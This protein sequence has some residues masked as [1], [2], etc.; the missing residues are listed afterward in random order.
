[1]IERDRDRDRQIERKSERRERKG[2]RERK[3]QRGRNEIETSPDKL[4]SYPAV[5]KGLY[6]NH[7][8]FSVLDSPDTQIQ[9][10][11]T[12]YTLDKEEDSTR[13]VLLVREIVTFPLSVVLH[14]ILSPSIYTIAYQL[15][16]AIQGN[17][18]E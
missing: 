7:N 4:H 9:S 14:S 11:P 5:M 16:M 1:M 3:R 2:E 10:I 12:M 17:S 13:R 15:C 6:T 8:T 18:A